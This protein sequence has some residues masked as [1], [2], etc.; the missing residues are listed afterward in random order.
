MTAPLR[1]KLIR[2]SDEMWTALDALGAELGK[3]GSAMVRE[4]TAEYLAYYGY[5]LTEPI[6]EKNRDGLGRRPVER[7]R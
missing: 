5:E 3:T 7:V 6:R 2:M 4:A 1:G